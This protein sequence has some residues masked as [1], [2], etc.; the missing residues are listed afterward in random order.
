MKLHLFLLIHRNIHQYELPENHE[1]MPCSDGK[2]AGITSRPFSELSNH[3]IL[4]TVQP[5]F[6]FLDWFSFE[7]SESWRCR[8]AINSR[9]T[10][11]DDF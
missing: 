3:A 2:N 10:N 4:G 1:P 7:P 6:S 11:I 5:T 9:S 8:L